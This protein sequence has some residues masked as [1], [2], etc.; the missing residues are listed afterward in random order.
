[1][2]TFYNVWW[3]HDDLWY[4]DNKI[5]GCEAGEWRWVVTFEGSMG[6][7]PDGTDGAIEKSSKDPFLPYQ[8]HNKSCMLTLGTSK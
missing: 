4:E 7:S 1:M 5:N 2:L 3:S 8:I 6:Q